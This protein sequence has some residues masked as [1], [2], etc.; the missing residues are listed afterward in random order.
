MDLKVDYLEAQFWWRVGETSLLVMVTI[1]TYLSNR[2]KVNRGAINDL[3]KG[4]SKMEQ[5]VSLL[6]NEVKHLPTHADFSKMNE[7]L[8]VIAKTH[9]ELSGEMKGVKRTL[10]LIHQSLLE[11]S[12]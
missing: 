3:E 11:R 2:T 9:H 1:Y 7:K 12:K 8:S 5:R 10:D 6:E 4:F